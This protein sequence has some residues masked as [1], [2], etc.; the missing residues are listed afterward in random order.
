MPGRE[1]LDYDPAPDELIHVLLSRLADD[2]A[3][4]DLRRQIRTAA[5]RRKANGGR[6]AGA[7]ARMRRLPRDPL[8]RLVHLERL[9]SLDPCNDEWMI[10]VAQALEVCAAQRPELDFD[11]VRRWI[12]ELV[13]AAR[14]AG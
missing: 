3:N 4:L 10:K 5:L 6:P 11:P 14:E 8:Q 2:P 13:L 9:W 7:L 12:R 1:S